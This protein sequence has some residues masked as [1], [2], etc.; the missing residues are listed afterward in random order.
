MQ[1]IKTPSKPYF[2]FRFVVISNIY[3]RFIYM[4]VE[5]LNKPCVTL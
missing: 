5:T 2:S 1:M 3:R 4:C